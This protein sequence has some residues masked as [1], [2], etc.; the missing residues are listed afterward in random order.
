MVARS[1]RFR[2]ITRSD[3]DGLLCA[4]LL[5]DMDILDGIAC[6]VVVG[7]CVGGKTMNAASLRK[8]LWRQLKRREKRRQDAKVGDR[9]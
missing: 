2:L 4:M 5:K 8:T 6:G 9:A 7:V 1:Q 3:F